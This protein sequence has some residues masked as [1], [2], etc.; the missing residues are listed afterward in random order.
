MRAS[1]V[2]RHGRRTPRTA[3]LLHSVGQGLLVLPGA[4][5]LLYA[6]APDPSDPT[7]DRA[8]SVRL[9]SISGSLC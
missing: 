2:V 5:T 6:F 7:L 8:M 3:I 1:P 9:V 4:V